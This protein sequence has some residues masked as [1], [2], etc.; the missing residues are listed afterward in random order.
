MTAIKK[1]T[2][3]ESSGRW[4]ETHSSESIEVLITFGKTSVVLSDYNDNPLTH[5]S[6]AA[7]RL[8]SK[9]NGEAIFSTDFENGEHLRVNDPN[10]INALLLFINQEET[11]PKKN[12]R[13]VYFYFISFV[14]LSVAII[15]Y[16][17]SK[18]KE[19]TAS[20]ISEQ[21][22][23]QLIEPFLQNHLQA[24]GGAC[25]S[26]KTETILTNMLNSVKKKNDII[27]ISIVRNQEMNI[28]H[29]PSGKLLM[30]EFFLKNA[31]SQNIL[32]SL[33]E[34]ELPKARE[35]QPLRTLI[36]QQTSFELTRFVLGYSSHLPVQSINDFLIPS[37]N[38]PR[39][40]ITLI[41]DFSWVAL[42]NICLN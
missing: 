28:L 14:V 38:L 24:S 20:I 40:K 8:V 32:V 22:E 31:L 9:D 16:F 34:S 15:L 27:S 5:W 21:H 17:P 36:N 18:L 35:R 12:Y 19:L 26:V 33:I 41:D 2:R 29:L 25:Y 7:I 10:M 37:S 11:H 30:S 23:S 3:L 39:T 1:Y 4:R 6:L 13:S 42:Q